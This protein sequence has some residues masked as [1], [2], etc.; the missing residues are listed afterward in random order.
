VV[1]VNM[2]CGLYEQ[3]FKDNDGVARGRLKTLVDLAGKRGYRDGASVLYPDLPEDYVRG[4]S[5]NI[6]SLLTD[7]DFTSCG[8]SLNGGRK[9]R[10]I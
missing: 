10:K 8:V 7:D 1:R 6:S 3:G 2:L 5:W 4:V 9:G